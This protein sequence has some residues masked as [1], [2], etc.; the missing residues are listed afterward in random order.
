MIAQ[1]PIA[2]ELH[3][4]FELYGPLPSGTTLLEASAGTGKTYAIATLTARF[5][6]EGHPLERLLV[7]TF[8][9]AATGEL[10]SRV[11]DRLRSARDGLV[12]A[13]A[14]RAEPHDDDLVRLL[15]DGGRQAALERRD[16]LTRA[17]AQFD[18]ATIETTHGFCHR[19]LV[20]LGV[21]GDAARSLELVE[22]IDHLLEEVVDDLFVRKYVRHAPPDLT[23]ADAL[24]LA[25][26]V[27]R[28]PSAL[29]A[30]PLGNGPDLASIRRRLAEAVR[31]E[32]DRRKRAAGLLTYDDILLRLRDTL[33]N[34]LRGPAARAR[35]RERY[36]VVLIDEFQDTDPV[37]WDIVAQTFGGGAATLVLIGDPKQAIY[38]FRGADVQAY[39]AAARSAATR[40]TL[41][42]NWRSDGPLVRALD[43]LLLDAQLGDADIV[44]RHVA[45][46]TRNDVPRLVGAPVGAALR[47]RRVARDALRTTSLGDVGADD[48]R[49]FIADDLAGDVASLLSSGAE[50]EMEARSDDRPAR[51]APIQPGH[52]AVLVR[53]NADALL[54]RRALTARGVPAVVVAPGSVF[55]TASATEWLRLL[56]ALEQPTSRARAAAAALTSFLGWDAGRLAMAGDDDLDRLHGQLHAWA[57]LLRERGLA[58]LLAAIEGATRLPARLLAQDDGERRLT[59]LHHLGELLHAEA[60]TTS[61]G[62]AALATWLRERIAESA[63]PA[64]ADARAEERSRRLESDAA[65]VQVLTIHRSKG[66]EFP[67]V[68]CPFLWHGGT[69]RLRFPLFHDPTAGGARTLDVGG[70]R[71]GFAA[72]TQLAIAEA[73]GEDLRVCYVALTRARHQVVCWWA[74]TKDAGRSPLGRLLFAREA[75]GS[76]GNGGR[77]PDDDRVTARLQALAAAAPGCVALEPATPSTATYRPADDRPGELALA[78]LGRALDTAWRRL[79]YTSLTAPAHD[80]SNRPGPSGG[81]GPSGHGG[82]GGL[83]ELDGLDGEVADEALSGGILAAAAGTEAAHLRRI[84]LVLAE[85]PGGAAFGTLVHGLLERADFVAD[86]LAGD[87]RSALDAELVWRR[88]DVGSRGVLVDGLAA[89]LAT[90]L[91]PD[92]GELC[93]NQVARADRLDELGFELPLVGGDDPH[94]TLELAGLGELLGTRLPPDDPVAAYA[95]RL[96]DP[97]IQ[98]TLR[99]YLNGSLD[100]VLRTGD[101][102]FAVCDYKTNRLVSAEGSLTAHD[103]RPAALAEE[104]AR[105]HYPLQALFYLVALHRYLRW[106]LPAYDPER[107][108]AGAHYLFLRGMTGNPDARVGHQPCGVWSW[109]PPPGM[110][111]TV[112]DLLDEGATP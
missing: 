66:L 76:V 34:P 41:A 90:P 17:L 45:P 61:L 11:R 49:R 19:V 72:Q 48:A 107:H 35:L 63:D 8:T 22:D 42:T 80:G 84:P 58:S 9:R 111:E 112:S 14:T 5:V 104:M 99:G 57:G 55:A 88:V 75:D 18:A 89:A 79:S 37:Q 39:L 69:G 7:I 77:N 95:P 21:A 74:P 96:L 24:E 62:P 30:P 108:L 85:A 16:R 64:T 54:V 28:N 4:P 105:C 51:R 73:R 81:P 29:L 93:L 15:W 23:R 109:Q 46:A 52:V 68:Y 33:G 97:A 20:E 94:G 56:Q 32:T 12:R 102:R 92:L 50:V 67:V 43:A 47:I 25:Q 98:A 100:L 38:A 91:G 65:A 26:Q 71:P 110:V 60:T 1:A 53:R 82:P 83:D 6:A 103:Y 86:D 87:L 10:R 2:G 36:E 31:T 101:G 59:D 13:L 44:Y 106:R 40:A 70:E 3:A 78:R 27:L